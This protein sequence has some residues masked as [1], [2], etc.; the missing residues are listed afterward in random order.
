MKY[1]TYLFWDTVDS[2]LQNV[3]WNYYKKFSK[4][5][6]ENYGQAMI[7]KKPFP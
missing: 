4:G 5:F 3:C 2:K 7:W 1:Y 6:L